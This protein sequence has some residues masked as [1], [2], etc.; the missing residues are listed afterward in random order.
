MTTCTCASDWRS[1]PKER[2]VIL[3]EPGARE[4]VGNIVSHDASKV[5]VFDR[6]CL[7]H[8]YKEVANVK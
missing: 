1:I 3:E 6:D 2:R 5:H 8:G 4:R 7:L